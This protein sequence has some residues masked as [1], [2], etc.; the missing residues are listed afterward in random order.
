MS[1]IKEQ[2][3]TV[4]ALEG[5][6]SGDWTLD[7][8]GV[9]YGSPRDRDADGEYFT[10]STNLHED[11]FELPPVVYF[12]GLKSET[13][14]YIGQTVDYEDRIDGRW[15]RVIL[16]KT[17]ALAQKVWEAAQQGRAGA[18]SGSVAHLARV[19]G[20]GHIQEWP[21]AE[22]TLL[23]ITPDQAP[24]NKRAVAVPV[25]K[26]MY[27]QA[28][29]EFPASIEDCEDDDSEADP[30]G[31]TAQADQAAGGGAIETEGNTQDKEPIMNEDT[32]DA[33][34]TRD[35]VAG[36]VSQGIVDALKAQETERA[37]IKEAED[38]RQKE[39]DDALKAQK[40]ELETKY[41]A[42]NRLP[43]TAENAP[44]K[45]EFGNLWKYDNLDDG[46]VALGI[47]VL[48]SAHRNGRSRNGVSEDAYK[49]LA[50]RIAESKR[51]EHSEAKLVMLKAGMPLK[52]N[53]LNQ[54]TLASYG[55]EWVTSAN[56]NQ[57]W[58]KVVEES[59][60]ASMIPTIIVPQ[61]AESVIIPIEGAAPTFYVVA[62]ASAQTSSLGRPTGTVTSSKYGTGQRTLTVGKLGASTIWTG[63]LEEDAMVNYV[64]ELRRQLV[65]EGALTMDD[66]VL[67]GDTAATASTN[68][69]DIAGTPAG[70]EAFMLL[71]GFR[72][73]ALVTNTANSR[74]AGALDENDYLETLKL[75]GLGGKNA[76]DPR[77][78]S[79]I[80][81][82]WTGWKAMD[83][84]VV[85]TRDV[86]SVPTVERGALTGIWGYPVINS[87]VM[88]RANADTT[89]NNAYG[90]ILAV[91]W[92]QWRLGIKRRMTI[93]TARYANSDANEIVAMMRIGLN[94]R[95]TDAAAI[96][97]GVEL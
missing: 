27:D 14:A 30:R 88:H 49:A 44:F 66:V 40:E 63:E 67:N 75:M 7:V 47:E 80:Q 8:L 25:L 34:I 90:A 15:Y 71:D 1:S 82:I 85:K 39:L 11:K 84:D 28:G 61:G 83:L 48:D 19:A 24:R 36:L 56:S 68:V 54:S 81:D 23:D 94:Y 97:Y 45:A 52:A 12:H 96:S 72:K 32:H 10:P 62:Q 22:L 59:R 95:D 37:A 60:I 35:E 78:V 33:A 69:N 46:E 92:T 76:L 31:A 79:F 77:Q 38:K 43:F 42:E 55:D 53:E 89:Y 26:A 20:S 16:D 4:K 58:L 70:T 87:T 9:P 17:K 51:D 50:V 3:I 74:A 64:G 13:P 41:A 21:I 86:F 65:T 73:L 6:E 93:E 5:G 91:N 18:S 29:L 57:L 2:Q